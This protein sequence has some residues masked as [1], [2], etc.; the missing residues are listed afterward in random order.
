MYGVDKTPASASYK[1]HLPSV[2]SIALRL[3][4]FLEGDYEGGSLVQY[5]PPTRP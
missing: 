3:T 5:Q 4:T 2:T 1:G